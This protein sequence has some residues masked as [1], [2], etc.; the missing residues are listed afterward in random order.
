MLYFL[1]SYLNTRKYDNVKNV[2]NKYLK[3][4]IGADVRRAQ[5]PVQTNIHQWNASDCQHTNVQ[6]VH[7]LPGSNTRNHSLH[8]PVIIIF[9]YATY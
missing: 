3:I 4:S 7:L 2:K 6:N 5:I 1:V 9:L 8:I